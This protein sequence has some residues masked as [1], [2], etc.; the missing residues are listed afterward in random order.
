MYARAVSIA[1]AATIALLAAPIAAQGR[2]R[3]QLPVPCGQTWEASTYDGHWPD[4]DSLDFGLWSTNTW[5]PFRVNI[6]EGQPVLASA[7]GEVSAVFTAPSGSHRVYLDHGG[8][9]VTHYI[10]NEEVPPLAVGQRVAQGEQIG[11]T[12]NSGD[13]TMHIHY[14]QL[15]DGQ[16]VRSTFNGFFVKSH[17]GDASTWGAWGTARAEKI[18]S[19]NCAGNTFLGWS[20]GGERY[21]L[22]YKPSDG[23]VKILRL[24][25]NGNGATTTWTGRWNRDWTHFI[26][27]TRPST[28]QP[29]AILYKSST[30]QA[31]FVRLHNGGA[32]L[33]VVGTANWNGG[34]TTFVPFT[35]GN[36]AYFVA[37][38]SLHGD[39]SFHRIDSNGG[40]S[41]RLVAETW[42]TGRTAIVPYTLGSRLFLLLYKGGDGT[43]EID[44]ITGSGNSIAI[45]EVWSG[46]WTAG[47]TDLVPVT[48]DGARYLV[49]YKVETGEAAVFKP[50]AGGQGVTTSARTQWTRGWTA[51][52]PL[53]I[54]GKGNLLI[55]KLHTGEV[56]TMRLRPNGAGFETVWQGIWTLGWT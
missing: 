56:R 30:G 8:G 44:E 22:V 31:A 26:P 27:F 28:G 41:T 4:E 18:T 25:D 15:E 11:R 48:H 14:T 46:A 43:V 10:H 12:S 34:W 32:G 42:E 36:V 5:S 50:R 39:A 6:S 7:S 29:H 55:Y 24:Y 40:G 20:Q 21:H 49:G 17:A 45:Q 9:W 13:D 38:D 19:V 1:L 54:D 3:F 2:P 35:R 51:F 33:T 53:T 16:A 23:E 52:S 47:W 37:Y